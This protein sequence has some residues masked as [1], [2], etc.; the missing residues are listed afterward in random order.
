VRPA[1]RALVTNDDGIASE[2]LR[3]LA[4]MAADLGLEVVVAAPARDSSGASASLTAVE[5]DGRVVVE[6]RSLPGLDGVP[7]FAV[8]AVPAFIALIATRGAFGPPPDVVLSGVNLGHN[9]GH[10]VLHSGTVGAAMTAC[11]AGR[12]ALAVSIGAGPDVHWETAAGLAREALLHLLDV[13]GPLVLNLNVPNVAPAGVRGL[14]RARLAG[15]GAVQTTVAEAGEGF[16]KIAVADVDAE[17]EEGTDAALLAAGYASITP[18]APICED[19]DVELAWT[20][21]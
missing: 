8:H 21:G 12:S 18:L 3:Q 5:A 16:V 14:R 17:L 2:G 1:T 9:T 13:P 4:R 15:F 10:A 11:T 20:A 19:D 6:P 7:A